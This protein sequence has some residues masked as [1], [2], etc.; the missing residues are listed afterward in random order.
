MIDLQ[1]EI[2]RAKNAKFGEEIWRE[3]LKKAWVQK[4]DGCQNRRFREMG[5]GVGKRSRR[6]A[7]DRY[8]GC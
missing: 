2:N 1:M 6:I 8:K 7:G 4:Q 5:F 3:D